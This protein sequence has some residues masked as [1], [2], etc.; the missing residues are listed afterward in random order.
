MNTDFWIRWLS[1][2]N[3]KIDPTYK[4]MTLQNIVATL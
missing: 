4:D 2:Q 1:S 3:W